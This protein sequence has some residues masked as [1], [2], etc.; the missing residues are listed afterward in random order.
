MPVV[1]ALKSR[2]ANRAVAS[3]RVGAAE[4]VAP[5]WTRENLSPA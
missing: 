1:V 4:V 3:M 5:P 2:D